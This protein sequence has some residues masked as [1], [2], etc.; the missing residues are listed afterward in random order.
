MERLKSELDGQL[1]CMSFDGTTRL[2]EAM[3]IVFRFAPAD[4][5][6]TT[7]RLVDFTAREQHMIGAELGQ[8]INEVFTN[9]V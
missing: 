2:S 3:N 7:Q 9:R 8:H 1:V 5:S 4:F 6:Y